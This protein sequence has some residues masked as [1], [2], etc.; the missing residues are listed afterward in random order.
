MP[1]EDFNFDPSDAGQRIQL[2][3]PTYRAT[4]RKGRVMLTGWAG[5]LAAGGMWNGLLDARA[6]AGVAIADLT[7]GGE[8]D[9]EILVR[10]LSEG[11]SREDAD[12]ALREWA[13]ALGYRRI[14]FPDYLAELDN[15]PPVGARAEVRCPTCGARWHDSTADFWQ[16]VREM[17]S[18]P[19]W[20]VVCGWELPQWEVRPA[21]DTR[22]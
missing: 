14:W 19:K 16:M 2:G 17:G 9:S 7:L 22:G 3:E 13:A 18:F 6:R 12:Q 10:Y 5:W 20:C 21:A 8:D 1:D 11:R 4:I 15:D